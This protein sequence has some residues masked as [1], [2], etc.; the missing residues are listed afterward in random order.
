MKGSIL[1]GVY[2]TRPFL[3]LCVMATST[4][5]GADPLAPPTSPKQTSP[6]K[7]PLTFSLYSRIPHF[8][9]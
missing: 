7:Y 4:L 3:F 5:Q 9:L 8:C 2:W 1:D 6:P